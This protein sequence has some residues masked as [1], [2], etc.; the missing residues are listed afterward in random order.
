MTFERPA[1]LVLAATLV[2]VTYMALNPAPPA[3]P[4]DQYGDKIEHM[5]AFATLAILAAISFPTASVWKIGER[6]SF[7]GALIE[8]F[9]AIPSLHRDC[10]WHDWVADTFAL[11][12]ALYLFTLAK[13][14]FTSRT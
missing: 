7:F 13:R 1:R 2:F 9:Q 5:S 8:V 11:S 14:H 10:D 4:L 12:V 6:L 3:T